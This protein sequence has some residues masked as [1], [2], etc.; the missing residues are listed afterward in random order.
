MKSEQEIKKV[1]I[2]LENERGSLE[3]EMANRENIMIICSNIT[4]FFY[5]MMRYL[6]KY[7]CCNGYYLNNIIRLFNN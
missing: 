2:Q 7:E 5:G 3:N 4:I 6:Q 1:F